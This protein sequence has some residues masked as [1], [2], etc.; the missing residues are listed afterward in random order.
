[1][2]GKCTRSCLVAFSSNPTT[3]GALIL[4]CVQILEAKVEDKKKLTRKKLKKSCYLA[5]SLRGWAKKKDE[6]QERERRER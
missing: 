1:M 6:Q 2:V 4:S 3:K 5:S